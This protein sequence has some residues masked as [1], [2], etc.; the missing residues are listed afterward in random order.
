M[1]TRTIDFFKS[2]GITAVFTSLTE[3]G[4]PAEQSEAAISTLMDTWLILQMAE[5]ANER[6]RV[7]SVLKSRGMAHSHQMR[8]FRFNGRGIH[9]LDFDNRR[10]AVPRDETRARRGERE[11]GRSP[12]PPEGR[13]GS[14]RRH[15]WDLKLYI[16]GPTPRATRALEN[17]KRICEEHLRGLYRI[18]VVDLL[19]NPRLARGDQIVAVPTLVRKL[20]VPVRKIIGDLSDAERVLIGLDLRP[21][22]GPASGGAPS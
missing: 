18:E 6:R 11:S 22:K 3:A 21:R 14:R 12:R 19:K 10:G 20:P 9:L 8:E 4:S 2:E 13:D 15:G 17:L 1:L 5:V 7:L 16:A